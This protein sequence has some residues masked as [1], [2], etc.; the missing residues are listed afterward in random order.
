MQAAAGGTPE[1]A[2]YAH[3]DGLGSIRLLTDAM[4]ADVGTQRYDPYGAPVASTGRTLVFGYTGQQHDA[5]SG[6]VYLRAWDLDPATGPVPHARPAAG[7][8][9]QS[10]ESAPVLLRRERSCG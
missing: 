8:A 3:Q 1:A 5:E 9:R 7:D 4:G 2:T 10:G 6:L